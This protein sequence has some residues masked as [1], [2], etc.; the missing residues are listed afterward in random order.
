MQNKRQS[1]AGEERGR[2]GCEKQSCLEGARAKASVDVLEIRIWEVNMSNWKGKKEGRKEWVG[3][4]EIRSG[5]KVA[6]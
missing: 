5:R 4:K 6:I 3:G 2:G 1:E